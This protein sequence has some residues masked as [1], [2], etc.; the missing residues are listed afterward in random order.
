MINEITNIQKNVDYRKLKII[1]GDKKEFDFS[2]YR[3]F[4]EIC[5]DLYYRAITIDEAES[6]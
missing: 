2:N 3:K 6:K 1:G 5:R 4:K